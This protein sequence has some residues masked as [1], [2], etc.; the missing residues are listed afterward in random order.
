MERQD[1]PPSVFAFD[2]NVIPFDPHSFHVRISLYNVEIRFMMKRIFLWK[3]ELKNLTDFD[4]NGKI[5][6][7]SEYPMYLENVEYSVIYN[8]AFRC[9]SETPGRKSREG[10]SWK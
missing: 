4:T 7:G 9:G 2:I 1:Q 3:T 8:G 5:T 10:R 6:I